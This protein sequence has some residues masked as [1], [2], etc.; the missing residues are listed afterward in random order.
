[1]TPDQRRESIGLSHMNLSD[2]DK[3]KAYTLEE[4]SYDYFR[5]VPSSFT[6]TKT[7]IRQWLIMCVS[8]R[9]Q[10]TSQE[11]SE[12][13]DDLEDPRERSSVELHQGASETAP[14]EESP[15]SRGAL[16][17]GLPGLYRY[18]SDQFVLPRGPRRQ[19]HRKITSSVVSLQFIYKDIS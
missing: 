6:H 8:H 19:W 13:G 16:P 15:G 12:Q 18:P 5:C 4:F 7:Q 14:A 17:R 11:H 9:F 10:A 1:M 2:K 3:T